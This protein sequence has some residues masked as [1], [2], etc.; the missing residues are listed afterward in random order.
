M[1]ENVKTIAGFV[2]S[3]ASGIGAGILISKKRHDKEL[4]LAKEA[5]RKAFESLFTKKDEDE[6]V[7]EDSEGIHEDNRDPATVYA[8][9]AKALHMASSIV[10]NNGY[11][12][13]ASEEKVIEYA[14]IDG[15]M[16]GKDGFEMVEFT[17]YESDH[18]MANEA[19]ELIRNPEVYIGEELYA[20]FLSGDD[21]EMYVRN[22]KLNLDI[23]LVKDLGAY[24]DLLEERPQLVSEIIAEEE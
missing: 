18:R 8:E 24:E 19:N 12:E 16:A 6:F 20:M 13:T 15:D 10:T 14:E 21:D 5:N 3:F 4:Q 9:S 1:T 22:F 7:P 11:S 2:I 17:Y 23:A